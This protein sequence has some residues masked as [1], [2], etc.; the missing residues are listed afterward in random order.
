[1]ILFIF[2]DLTYDTLR[3]FSG[4]EQAKQFGDRMRPDAGS[5][6]QSYKLLWKRGDYQQIRQVE[7][8]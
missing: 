5:W 2:H 6:K 4:L 3:V 1:M 7:L 8:E